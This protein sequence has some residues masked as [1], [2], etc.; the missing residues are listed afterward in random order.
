MLTHMK[1]GVH[2]G[3]IPGYDGRPPSK[4]TLFKAGAE[5]VSILLGLNAVFSSDTETLAMYGANSAGVFA[6]T[7]RLMDRRGQPVGEG[8]GVAELREPN[9][10]GS[11]N[12]AAKMG[13]KRAFVDAVLRAG[14]LSNFFTQDLEEGVPLAPE[15]TPSSPP[16]SPPTG[17]ER[18]NGRVPATP[19][20]I[21]SIRAWLRQHDTVE[22][23]LLAK[24]QIRALDAAE[25]APGCEVD[26]PPA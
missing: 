21:R 8:R 1:L 5:L 7:C 25:R 10:Y 16:S 2:Y 11:P 6:Y 12:V 14:G 20:Q 23:D 9:F 3:I 18:T 26:H 17:V 15:Q 19:H 22:D 4:P 24:L 13:E